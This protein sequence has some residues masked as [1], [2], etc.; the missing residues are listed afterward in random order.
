M[1]PSLG[2]SM[3]EATE[4]GFEALV[5]LLRLPVR[6]R[7]VG[8]AQAKFS[9]GIAKKFLP[10]VTRENRIPIRDNGLRKPMNWV[11][12]LHEQLSHSGSGVRVGKRQKMSELGHP[13]DQNPDAVVLT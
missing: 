10:E 1:S 11:D 9:A 12:A 4:K 8:G 7:V 13:V 2:T 3:G 6:L 5:H